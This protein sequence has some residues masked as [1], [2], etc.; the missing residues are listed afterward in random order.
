MSTAF[1]SE[2]ERFATS[3]GTCNGADPN[4]KESRIAAKACTLGTSLYAGHEYP[5][6][7]FEMEADPYP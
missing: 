7:D 6:A 2:G 5:G 3:R 1:T 4:G